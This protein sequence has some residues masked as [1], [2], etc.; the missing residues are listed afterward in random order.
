MS[1]STFFAKNL[2]FDGDLSTN[3]AP[4]PGIGGVLSSDTNGVF[5]IAVPPQPPS[6]VDG[7][8]LQTDSSSMGGVKWDTTLTNVGSG[9]EIFVSPSSLKTL[10]SND[11]SVTITS[12]ATEIDLSTPNVW[13]YDFFQN[14]YYIPFTG[15]AIIQDVGNNTFDPT[16]INA[17]AYNGMYSGTDNQINFLVNNEGTMT[18]CTILGG[19]GNTIERSGGS[20]AGATIVSGDN[21]T[22]DGNFR[23]PGIFCS[24]NVDY[25]G[26]RY[27]AFI[28]QDNATGTGASYS[29]V[30]GGIN[31]TIASGAGNNIIGSRC[32]VTGNGNLLLGDNNSGSTTLTNIG[33]NN[34]MNA[35]FQSGYNFFSNGALSIGVAL[36]AGG[37]SWSS[38]CDVNNKENL[39]NVGDDLCSEIC[40]KFTNMS[41]YLYNYIGNPPEQVCIGPTAQDWHTAFGCEDIDVPVYEY[42]ENGE[43][44][45]SVDEDGELVFESS[46][47]K[48][49]LRIETMD[50]IGVLMASVKSLNNRLNEKDEQIAALVE[51]VDNVRQP[52]VYFTNQPL[53]QSFLSGGS[54]TG[55]KVFEY[56]C[57][58]SGNISLISSTC[59]KKTSGNSGT[60]YVQLRLNGQLF[61]PSI[62]SG[63]EGEQ[64]QYAPDLS[65]LTI[66]WSGEVNQGDILTVYGIATSGTFSLTQSGAF[67][68]AVGAQLTITIY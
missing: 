8:T 43:R 63:Y 5:K 26:G 56:A 66:N 67:S 12:T 57:Q 41:V 37:S 51:S 16:F 13:D 45:Q 3:Q 47:A 49:P 53:S 50:M 44:S 64:S 9:E 15:T 60:I 27:C 55:T 32:S 42:N 35:R 40:D 11:S 4:L 46:P 30:I 2:T 58:K 19:I 65:G 36:A 24:E 23:Y 54:S 61:N 22:L 25:S 1:S 28:A 39:V 10:T 52:E 14:R 48:D 20:P 17:Q 21:C 31:N 7:L 29:A 59:F 18:G 68:G 38:V 34:S 33:G 6:F 62:Q